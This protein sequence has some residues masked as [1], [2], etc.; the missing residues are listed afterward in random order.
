WSN[1]ASVQVSVPDHPILLRIIPASGA[2]GQPVPQPTPSGPQLAVPI[3]E[4]VTAGSSVA[5]K[6]IVITDSF[7][8]S[9]PGTLTLN[10]S[11]GPGVVA[12]TANGSR[13]AGSGTHAISVTG[14]LAQINAELATLSYSAGSSAG[15]DVLTIDVWDQAGLEGTKSFDIAVKPAT[16]A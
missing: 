9:N 15:N 5:V 2:G 10:V 16:S 8:A 12:M 6:G 13:V 7:A 1:V 14:T 11:A 3:G 4:T